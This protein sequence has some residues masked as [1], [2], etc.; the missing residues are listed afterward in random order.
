MMRIGFVMAALA[1]VVLAGCAS[2]ESRQ[3]GSFLNPLCAPDGSVVHTQYAN[4]KGNFDGVKASVE[5][6]P[7]YKK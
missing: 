4:S 5:Y 2:G 7:W 6:C 3:A 1:A